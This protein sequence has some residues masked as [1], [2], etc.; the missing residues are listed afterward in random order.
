[1]NELEEILATGLHQLIVDIIA[2]SE[3]HG[4]KASGR[5]YE[6]IAQEV[7][8]TGELVEGSVTAPSYFFTL[9]RGRGAGKVPAEMTEIIMEWAGYKGITFSEPQELVRFANA[10]AWKIRR[11]GTQMYRRGEYLDIIETP[12]RQ[13]EEWFSAM[14]DN[15]MDVMITRAFNGED[16]DGRGSII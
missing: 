9:I 7:N 16:F 10:V 13:F 15:V 4:Q 5:T 14:I 2:A 1:M 6:M 12:I 3:A 11:E 8:R